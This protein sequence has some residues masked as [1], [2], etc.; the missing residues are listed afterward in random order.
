MNLKDLNS[1]YCEPFGEYKLRRDFISPSDI[2]GCKTPA[3]YLWKRENRV[4]N[5]TDDTLL[6]SYFHAMVLEPD[7][8]EQEFAIWKDGMKP[9]PDKNYTNS[10]NKKA[11]DSFI[12]MSEASGKKVL[13]EEL[14]RK[15]IGMYEAV[16]HSESFL[17]IFNRDKGICEYS[18]LACAKLLVGFEETGDHNKYYDL[19]IFNISEAAHI[20]KDR[21]ILLKVRPDYV[22]KKNMY[23][24]DVKTSITAS[25]AGRKFERH[26]YDFEYH[27]QAAM[28]IDIVTAAT[29]K[30]FDDFFF[31]VVEKTEPYDNQVFLC[32]GDFIEYG[33]LQYKTRLIQ[34]K[35]AENKK[36]YKSYD[37]Y[38]SL[39]GGVMMLDV[40]FY[41]KLDEI[42]F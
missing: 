16:K 27:I 24:A 1:I 40:P 8:I 15:A 9:F 42:K 25:P 28:Y 20:P 29:D 31:G 22:S 4:F 38:S 36:K 11:R 41:A 32:T 19:Q 26:S 30:P 6:G 21:L 35:L 13:S 23:I 18:F 39:D 14:Y 10:E 3:Q 34:I 2:K 37:V 7:I 17:P 33:R 12:S 5:E